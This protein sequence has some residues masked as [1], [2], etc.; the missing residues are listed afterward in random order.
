MRRFVLMYLSGGLPASTDTG[1][2]KMR[3]RQW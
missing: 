3:F 1:I 2:N